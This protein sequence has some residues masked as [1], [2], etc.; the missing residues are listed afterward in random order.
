VNITQLKAPKA[1][2]SKIAPPLPLG[3]SKIEGASAR[4]GV[5]RKE[6]V[7]HLITG[8][9]KT[10]CFHKVQRVWKNKNLK[11]F[12]IGNFGDFLTERKRGLTHEKRRKRGESS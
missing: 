11:K 9:K 10:K 2:R 12:L 5:L 1:R 6:E 8:G 7:D 3:R 4:Q